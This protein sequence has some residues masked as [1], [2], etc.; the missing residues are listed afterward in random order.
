LQATNNRSRIE[1]RAAKL[2]SAAEFSRLHG[3]P[4]RFPPFRHV[5][6][7]GARSSRRFDRA[8]NAKPLG[9]F[10]KIGLGE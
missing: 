10:P 5:S 4:T 1:T 9:R 3:A 7:A 6:M 8:L 2:G